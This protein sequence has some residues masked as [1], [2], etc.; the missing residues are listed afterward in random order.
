MD[1]PN[2]TLSFEQ[3]AQLLEEAAAGRRQLSAAAVEQM[4]RT[5]LAGFLSG[6]G[7]PPAPWPEWI[8]IRPSLKAELW[9][10]AVASAPKG[11]ATL[12]LQ[13]VDDLAPDRERSEPALDVARKGIEVARARGGNPLDWQ[14]VASRSAYPEL[15]TLIAEWSRENVIRMRG[16]WE[17]AYIVLSDDPGGVALAGA[18]VP[19]LVVG[20]LVTRMSDALRGPHE[21]IARAWLEALATSPLRDVVPIEIKLDLPAVAGSMWTPL[22]RLRGS[23]DGVSPSAEPAP[24]EQ[25]PFLER[26]LETLARN[27]PRGTPD[28]EGLAAQLGGVLS[29]STERSLARWM[30]PARP[31]RAAAGAAWLTGLAAAAREH[32]GKLAERGVRAAREQTGKLAEKGARAAREHA[33]KLRTKTKS[34]PNP[35]H[36]PEREPTPFE[37]PNLIAEPAPQTAL[38]M[39]LLEWVRGGSMEDDR[40]AD[41]EMIRLFESGTENDLCEARQAIEGFSAGIL[42]RLASRAALNPR[43]LD[44]VA[45]VVDAGTLDDILLD[46]VQYDLWGFAPHAAERLART[47][48]QGSVGT[49]EQAIVRLLLNGPATARE[50]LVQHLG[51]VDRSLLEELLG[52]GRS[53]AA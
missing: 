29:D 9:M 49:V 42:Y 43:L 26:E 53:S 33:A 15:R 28:L 20:R 38:Q 7:I 22:A 21:A 40:R 24:L 50:A 12:A 11:W 18:N 30:K 41:E 31:Q 4:D 3:S 27:A 35:K 25:L 1:D 45:R 17:T 8:D 52:P 14:G 46:V 34:K 39:N 10:S 6:L 2:Q 32:G 48:R 13:A 36:E 23:Y 16:D 47:Y 19:A 37:P 51:A 5:A 44:G